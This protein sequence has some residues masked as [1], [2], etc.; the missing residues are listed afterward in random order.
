MKQWRG[1]ALRSV[2]NDP[3]ASRCRIDPEYDGP[4]PASVGWTAHCTPPPATSVGALR[5]PSNKI[6]DTT[7][8]ASAHI[9]THTPFEFTPHDQS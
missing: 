8:T 1:V 3:L 2:A 7:V 4:N 5:E 6:C 9:Y